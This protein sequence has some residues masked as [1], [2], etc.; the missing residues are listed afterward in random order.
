MLI[1]I[2]KDFEKKNLENIKQ[3]ITDK[4]ES[5]KNLNEKINSLKEEQSQGKRINP[6][7]IDN[8]QQQINKIYSDSMIGFILIN[9]PNNSVHSSE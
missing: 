8:L 4:R 5:I 1:L 3:E 6:R 2:R 9:F 7:D